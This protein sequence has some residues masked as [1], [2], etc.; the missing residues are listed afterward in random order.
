MTKFLRR[1]SCNPQ[2]DSVATIDQETPDK[3]SDDRPLMDQ[4]E[5]VMG[6]WFQQEFIDKHRSWH[7]VY[8]HRFGRS[9][10]ICSCFSFPDDPVKKRYVWPT[11]LPELIDIYMIDLGFIPFGRCVEKNLSVMVP[12]APFS[13][14]VRRS[15]A[16]N[17]VKKINEEYSIY[18]SKEKRRADAS[19]EV[20]MGEM[21]EWPES[22]IE[23]YEDKVL[24]RDYSFSHMTHIGDTGSR[25][26]RK[27]FNRRLMDNGI[28]EATDQ[29]GNY[30]GMICVLK[31][32]KDE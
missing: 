6:R 11:K 31:T 17:W 24:Y 28:L 16:Q 29:E 10:P 30:I 14:L 3:D 1:K 20:M 25:E 8:G 13:R 12:Q 5:E 4:M 18:C 2:Q 9:I 23:K 26:Y 32:A 27:F 15:F 7:A 19:F 21:G 22:K